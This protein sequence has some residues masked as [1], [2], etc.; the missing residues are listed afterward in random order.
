MIIKY[1]VITWIIYKVC[2]I[3]IIVMVIKKGEYILLGSALIALACLILLVPF[4]SQLSLYTASSLVSS[5]EPVIIE[6]AQE[7]NEKTFESSVAIGES[8]NFRIATNMHAGTFL[9]NQNTSDFTVSSL[10]KIAPG[11]VK[12]KKVEI[13]SIKFIIAPKA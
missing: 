4:I 5:D 13:S 9:I 10:E 7:F 11:N 2:G 12:P 6:L 8:N 1:F 3:Y